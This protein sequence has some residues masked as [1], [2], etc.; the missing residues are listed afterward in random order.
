MHEMHQSF[1]PGYRRIII[2]KKISSVAILILA[3]YSFAAA[4]AQEKCFQSGWL[5]QTHYINFKI[6]GGKVSGIFTVSRD[7]EDT[8]YDFTGAINANTVTV[9]FA[10]GKVP[11]ISPSEMRG[12]VWTLARKG[13]EE[14]LKIKVYGK[15]YQT[16]KYEISYAQYR[17]CVPSYAALA[18]AAKPVAFSKGA[19][20]AAIKLSF[21][22]NEESKVFLVNARKGQSMVVE[23][24]GCGVM[25][26]QPDK[27]LYYEVEN[28]G[29]A[30]SGKSSVVLDVASILSL[31][32]TG[33]YLVILKNAGGAPQRS[34]DV[35]FKIDN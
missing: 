31:P 25:I 2:M 12:P 10:G 9:K 7:G 26:Y 24:Y 20:S 29:E 32:Q 5:Q 16:N 35:I 15:N 13:T 22:D 28:P 3:F 11:D 1:H 8:G 33:N 4:Q 19:K 34:R 23:A 27:K 18:A 17:S 21:A 6:E 14:I 30:D